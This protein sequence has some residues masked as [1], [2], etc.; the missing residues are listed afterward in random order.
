MWFTQP[1]WLSGCPKG[2]L[3][4]AKNTFVLFLDAR[5]EIE[6]KKIVHFLE[7][8]KTSPEIYLPLA[9]RSSFFFKFLKTY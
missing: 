7:E 6:K 2:D 9:N 4:I 8:S 5:A 3:F 1:I